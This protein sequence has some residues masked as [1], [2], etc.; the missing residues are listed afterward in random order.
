M[1]PLLSSET[2]GCW[3]FGMRLSQPYSRIMIFK[4]YPFSKF[5]FFSGVL[6][7]CETRLEK[8]LG[9]GSGV[10]ALGG[11]PALRFPPNFSERDK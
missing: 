9:A 10:K 11:F 3:L 8:A 4:K 2:Q 5:L 6:G 7:A 1:A